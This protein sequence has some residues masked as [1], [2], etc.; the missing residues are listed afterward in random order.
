MTPNQQQQNHIK[1][2]IQQLHTS[3]DKLVIKKAAETWLKTGADNEDVL[4]ALIH[5][6]NSTNDEPTRW[7]A[8]QTLGKLGSGNE[9]VFI[10]LAIL[11][12]LTFKLF[13]KT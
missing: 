11:C 3:T 7:V 5:L 9:A 6:V 4:K 13:V 2:L 12:G 10:A 8:I 1:F